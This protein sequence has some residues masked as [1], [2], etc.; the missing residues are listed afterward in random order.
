MSHALKITSTLTLLLALLGGCASTPEASP[1]TDADAKRFESAPNAAIIYLYRP[2][3]P[4]GNAASTLWVDGRLIGET[5]STTFF[6]VAVRPGRNRISASGSDAGR[7][8]IDTQAAGIY[9][10]ETQVLGDAQGASTT[11]F[12]SVAPATGKAAILRCCNMLETW[13]PGQSRFNF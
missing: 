7:L 9:F 8:E 3:A 12:R 5:L 4:G 6:R 2:L 10:V 13:R 11:F 1:D